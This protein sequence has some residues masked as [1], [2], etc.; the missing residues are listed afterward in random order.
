M[1]RER[2]EELLLKWDRILTEFDK[3][4]ICILIKLKLK[5]RKEG[6]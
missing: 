5:K 2:F 4:I 1:D 3:K 6:Q